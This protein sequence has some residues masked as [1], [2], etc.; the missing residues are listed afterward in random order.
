MAAYRR[1]VTSEGGARFAL[2]DDVRSCCAGVHCILN[3]HIIGVTILIL[4]NHSVETDLSILPMDRA[5]GKSTKT[6]SG[7]PIVHYKKTLQKNL[8]IL[9]GSFGHTQTVVWVYANGCLGV[10]K[11]Q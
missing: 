1:P 8:G 3:R 10:R 4:V 11:R 5:F 6:L 7:I 9:E 2:D